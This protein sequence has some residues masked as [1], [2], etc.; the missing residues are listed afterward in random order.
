MATR[1]GKQTVLYQTPPTVRA[2]ASVAGKK[3][4]QGPLA[5][6]FDAVSDDSTFGQ[7]S[8]EKGESELMRR[9]ISILLKKAGRNPQEIDCIFAG[10]LLNQ[11]VGS[12]FGLRDFGIPLF[13]IYGACSTMSEGISLASLLVEA[14]S[15]TRAAAATSS[16]FCTAERQYRYPL[17]YGG[18]RPPTAQWTA[19][20]A[21]AVLIEQGDEPPFVRA[22]TFGTVEDKG[23]TDQNNMGAAMAPAAAATLLQFFADTQTGPDSFD[24]IV[25]GDLGM[26][27][28][29]LLYQ[30]TEAEGVDIRRQHA[31]CGLMLFDRERQDVHAGGSGCGCSAS[32]LC[33]FF[34]PALADGRMQNILFLATGALLS[35]TT[36]QQKESIPSISHLSWLSHTKGESIC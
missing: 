34:L 2:W 16:H 12:T 25:T 10:D 21:G 5:S 32:T 11:C 30:L 28:R 15:V 33:A 26:V 17:E 27:G 1:C 22:V 13:G 9:T 8:W 24:A 14:G 18:V 23:V 31:D 35:P 36:V 4:S 6:C 19:T 3:E 7:D 20:A 29:E